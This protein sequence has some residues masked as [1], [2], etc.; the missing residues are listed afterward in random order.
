MGNC[1]SASTEQLD[2]ISGNLFFN[3]LKK[4][5]KD[6]SKEMVI[7][8]HFGSHVRGYINPKTLSPAKEGVGMAWPWWLRDFTCSRILIKICKIG[9]LT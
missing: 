5:I 4:A 7:G 8:E 3:K 1:H 6:F 9:L 2:P